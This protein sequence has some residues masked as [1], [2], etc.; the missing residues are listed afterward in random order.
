MTVRLMSIK[1]MQTN[2]NLIDHRHSA[3]I[4]A[5]PLALAGSRVST[6]A[7]DDHQCLFRLLL[8]NRHLIVAVAQPK[9]G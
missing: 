3:A 2:D 8:H 6:A 5:R 9:G 1:T 4:A 7:L